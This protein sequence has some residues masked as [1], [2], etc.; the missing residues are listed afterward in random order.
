M[1]AFP[2]W[3]LPST[4]DSWIS[5]PITHL[6]WKYGLRLRHSLRSSSSPAPPKS[7]PAM[8]STSWYQLRII[9]VPFP[10]LLKTKTPGSSS[11]LHSPFPFF[12]CNLSSNLVSSAFQNT[13]WA[14][15]P[16]SGPPPWSSPPTSFTCCSTHAIQ[17]KR[18]SASDQQAST[19]RAIQFAPRYEQLP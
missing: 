19:S 13:W 4:A 1:S 10:A 16:P 7:A 12:L 8:Y 11:I 2:A 18:T 15:C 6:R 5:V 3:S 14:L 17:E 9:S